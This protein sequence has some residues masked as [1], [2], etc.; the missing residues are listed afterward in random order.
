MAEENEKELIQLE[1]GNGHK[2]VEVS[3]LQLLGF[4]LKCVLKDRITDEEIKTI[5][6]TYYETIKEWWG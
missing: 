3:P 4:I 5:C 1:T 6:T 2:P